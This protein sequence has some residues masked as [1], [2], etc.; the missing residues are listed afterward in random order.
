MSVFCGMA[1]LGERVD[2]LTNFADDDEGG[3]DSEGYEGGDGY[4]EVLAF[5]QPVV[6][7]AEVLGFGVAD[8]LDEFL[9]DLKHVVDSFTPSVC[10]TLEAGSRVRIQYTH[11]HAINLR[12][13]GMSIQ[14]ALLRYQCFLELRAGVCPRCSIPRVAGAE[15]GVG[16]SE[17]VTTIGE[18]ATNLEPLDVV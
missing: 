4:D 11:L 7:L 18:V 9:Q 6:E 16:K 15:D 2:E 10:S 8:W 12:S 3:D 14:R 13:L 1:L 5:I 17:V